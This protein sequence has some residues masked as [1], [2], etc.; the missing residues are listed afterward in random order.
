MV[1][2][3]RLVDVRLIVAVLVAVLPVLGRIVVPRIVGVLVFGRDGR[4]R[5]AAFALAVLEVVIG[6]GR[7]VD[8]RL[9][10]TV[11]VAILPV[12]RFV[13]VPRVVG[14]G[15]FGRLTAA[16]RDADTNTCRH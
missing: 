2:A 12:L 15:V 9:I 11:L 4:L 7:L 10:V 14:V 6:A 8:V 5:S 3:G 13:V 16:C 1:C